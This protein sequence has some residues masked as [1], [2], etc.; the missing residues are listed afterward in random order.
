[1]RAT[2]AGLKGVRRAASELVGALRAQTGDS[3]RVAVTSTRSGAG[4]SATTWPRGSEAT[5]A[6]EPGVAVTVLS[7]HPRLVELAFAGAVLGALAVVI[8][9]VRELSSS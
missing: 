6:R 1:M 3:L 4:G 2:G 5:I 8:W 7:K 9:F